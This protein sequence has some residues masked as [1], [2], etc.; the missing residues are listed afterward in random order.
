MQIG[1]VIAAAGQ[2][3][4]MGGTV[5]KQFIEVEG[6]AVLLH[7]LDIFAGLTEVSE[8]IVVTSAEDIEQTR[9]L[10]LPYPG[11]RVITGGAERQDSVR[12]GLDALRHSDY[13]LIH[14]GARPFVSRGTLKKLIRVMKDTGAAT[15]AVPVKDTIK[16]VGEHGVILS[17]P[18]RKSLWAV[19][20]PQAFHLS[21]IRE[22]HERA[23][24]D[25]FIGTDDAS[26]VER[27]GKT[28]FIVEG[29]YTNIKL[30]TPEDLL[31]GE[32]IL[33]QRMR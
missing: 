3:K 16:Q 1:V 27:T 30:T 17:T 23:R 12:L 25:G 7:T 5:K 19:Q 9:V 32:V 6:K 31:F 13:V 26:L 20:T 28:V 14:D 21:V 10:L 8:T 11:V 24:R 15:L 33:K 22:A 4:R 18:P 2:G 29:E